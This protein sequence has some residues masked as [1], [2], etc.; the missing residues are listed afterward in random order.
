MSSTDNRRNQFKKGIDSDSSRRRRENVSINIRKQKKEQG[1]AKRRNCQINNLVNANTAT[2]VATP[3]DA[4]AMAATLD[5]LPALVAGVNAV[6]NVQMN[7]AATRG[8]RKLLSA[9]HNPPVSQVI[10]AGVLP[11]LVE[12]LSAAHDTSLQFEAAWALTN[13]AST[14]HTEVVVQHG[15]V[16]PLA[17]LLTNANA[18]VREQAAWCLG[19]I[20]GDSPSLRDVVL[21]T[22]ALGFLIQNIQQPASNSM[23][24]NATWALSNFCR[25]KPQPELSLVANAVPVLVALLSNPDKEVLMDACWALSYLSDGDD[26]RIEC[27]VQSNAVPA[28]VQLLRHESSSVITPALRTIGNIVSGS[29]TQTQSVIDQG[30]LQAL[31]PLL[32]NPK[33]TVR[34][35]T[36][37]ALSNIAAGTKHQISILCQAPNVLQRVMGQLSNGE[38][39][40]KKEAAW[41]VSNVA[42][43]GNSDDV[44]ML[45]NS[46]CIAPIT[47]L[48]EVEDAKIVMVAL[49]AIDAILKHGG[50]GE[51]NEYATLVDEAEGLDKI[52]A[53]QEHENIDI[54]EKAVQLIEKYFGEEEE[55]CENMAPAVAEGAKTFD[56]GAPVANNFAAAPLGQFNFNSGNH[57]QNAFNFGTAPGLV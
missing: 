38:W 6:G 18:D 55:E 22:G 2:A 31:L 43:G 50:E 5:N 9:E 8:F 33:K 3:T 52:E 36:C 14:E 37:W 28:L 10:E 51:N 54:Y 13:V 47:E 17:Q 45:I 29:D 12:F 39:D 44:R 21:S 32:D 11:K 35:E 41:V 53:L 4:G 34:K 56:F 49:D 25:G 57:Q 30:G 27:V 48:L 40:V 15:A 19:N 46:G 1:L 7:L 42:T 20:A 26:M 23:L 24:R 16:P